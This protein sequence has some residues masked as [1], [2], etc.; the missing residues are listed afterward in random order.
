MAT[1]RRLIDANAL[2]EKILS[3]TITVTGLRTG[4][5]VLLELLAKYRE[6]ILQVVKEQP[7]VDAV[8]VV[9]GWWIY[10]EDTEVRW[11]TKAICSA[12]KCV[13]EHNIKLSHE[14]GR[15]D[16]VK[17]NKFCPNCGAK[18]DGKEN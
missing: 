13:V 6:G 7:T 14:Y 3:L 18:M 17:R 5:G 12:C 2:L 8:E 15:E 4:R 10:E 16:H 1:E 9:H 11:T